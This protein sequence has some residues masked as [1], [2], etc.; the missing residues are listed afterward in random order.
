MY[1][2]AGKTIAGN[3]YFHFLKKPTFLSKLSA[4][5]PANDAARMRKYV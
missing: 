1:I 3:R 4:S 5:G 2:N